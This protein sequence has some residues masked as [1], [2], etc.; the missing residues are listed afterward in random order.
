[1][2]V[3]V[4]GGAGFIGSHVVEQLLDRGDE[5]VVLDNLDPQV[6]GEGAEQ[7]IHLRRLVDDGDIRFLRGDVADKK[8]LE[9]ALESAEAVVHLA[10]AVGVGQ[11]MYEPLYYVHTNSCGTATLLELI[12][13]DRDKRIE[14]LVVASSMSLYGEGAYRCAECSGTTA[15]P[16]KEEHLRRGDWDVRCAD[17]GWALEPQQTPEEK[18]ADIASIYAATKKNQEELVLAFG[19]AYDIPSFAL[20]FFNVYGPRQSLSNPYTGVAAIFMSRLLNDKPP[21]VF[22]DGEQSRDFIYVEDIAD[23]VVRAVHHSGRGAQAVNV[24]T[25]R[26]LTIREVGTTLAELLEVDIEPERLGRFR[27][28][29]VRHCFADAARARELLEFEA[30][31]SFRDGM[32]RLVEWSRGQ[33][34]SDK[35]EE[36]LRELEAHQLVQ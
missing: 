30:T 11:S 5:V 21:I 10:A 25:G 6:H 18:P 36:S 33:V 35:V 27:A 19:R 32:Q 31:W 23:A 28:G 4:T 17:C 26:P 16:R 14:K 9:S 3:L 34:A 13:R 12:A 24:G 2:K 29:D 7:P 1:M 8:I 15:T 22:E 20:R